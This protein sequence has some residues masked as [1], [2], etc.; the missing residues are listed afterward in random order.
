M[1]ECE[2]RLAEQ[3]ARKQNE[4]DLALFERELAK[5]VDEYVRETRQKE[6]QQKREE[7]R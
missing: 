1:Q 4:L 6:D 2:I 5:A 7:I 3:E